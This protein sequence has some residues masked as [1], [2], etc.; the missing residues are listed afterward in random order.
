MTTGSYTERVRTVFAGEPPP[1]ELGLDEIKGYTSPK[2]FPDYIP[3]A[4]ES[5]WNLGDRAHQELHLSK[6]T[7]PWDAESQCP[8]SQAWLLGWDG[9]PLQR[10]A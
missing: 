1:V 7:N 3:P 9:V 6:R 8:E 5:A 10:G 2:Q 4:L